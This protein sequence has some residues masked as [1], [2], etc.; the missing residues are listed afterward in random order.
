LLFYEFHNLGSGR[1]T[2][3]NNSPLLS[4]VKLRALIITR[5]ILAAFRETSVDLIVAYII[6]SVPLYSFCGELRRCVI[7]CDKSRGTLTRT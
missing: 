6:Y 3:A 7:A 5:V 2:F 4:G 1:D